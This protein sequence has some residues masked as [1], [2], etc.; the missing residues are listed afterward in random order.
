MPSGQIMV[1]RFLINGLLTTGLQIAI[2]YA[3]LYFGWKIGKLIHEPTKLTIIE[4]IEFGL[5]IKLSLILF[6]TMLLVTNILAALINNKFLTWGLIC[7]MT[8]LYLIGWGE[9]FNTWP[10][11]TTLF[12]IAGLFT[13]FIKFTVDKKLNRLIL[14]SGQ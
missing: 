4:A 1:K 14:K 11:K 10:W 12:L 8:V 13:I 9:D 7:I 3:M 5:I 6:G 2:Y